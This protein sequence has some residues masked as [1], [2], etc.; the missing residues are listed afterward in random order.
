M[1]HVFAFG[2]HFPLFRTFM[3]QSIYLIT[4]NS[5]GASSPCNLFSCFGFLIPCECIYP[6]LADWGASMLIFFKTLIAVSSLFLKILV[7]FCFL[8]KEKL[9]LLNIHISYNFKVRI[10]LQNICGSCIIISIKLLIIIK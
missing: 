8:I 3:V 6:R 10:Q 9:K 1:L 4:S 5:C 2:Y 7:H